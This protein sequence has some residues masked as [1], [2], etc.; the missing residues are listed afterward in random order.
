MNKF[1]VILLGVF[2]FFII[3]GVFAF[4][5]FRGGGSGSFEPVTIWGTLESQDIDQ[6]LL[7][8]RQDVDKEFEAAY[9]EIPEEEFDQTLLEALAA[10]R[11]PDLVFLPE[12]LIV[13]HEDKIFVVPFESLSLRDFRDRFIE[14]GELYVRDDGILGLPFSV[15][16][17]VLYWNRTLFSNVGI[18]STPAYWDQFF[19]LSQKLTRKDERGN[20]LQGA[21]ALGEYDNV[22]HAKEILALLMLQAGTPIVSRANEG[23]KVSLTDKFNF[24]EVPAEA[25]LR[26]Y[27]EFANPVKNV[28]SWNRSLP[29]SQDAFV[30]GDIAMY[31]GFASELFAIQDR[32]PNLNFDVASLPQARDSGRVVTFGNMQA[33]SVMRGATDVNSA[34]N[35]LRVLTSPEVLTLWEDISGLP[36]V[37]RSL[38]Q[39]DPADAYRVVFHNGALVS[40]A[41]LDPNPEASDSIFENMI[42]DVT[43]GRDRISS[44][45]LGAQTALRELLQ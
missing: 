2:V 27:T 43:S 3:A 28:Y 1:Q 37:R 19:E 10:G 4:A 32:N 15:D 42:E 12:D 38:L 13:R 14:E 40:D 23:F 6:L 41:F 44:A 18:A 35:A 9:R 21:I 20:I 25:A 24:P 39:E 31:V 7:L 16:P 30:V 8:V 36:P 5:T 26:F 33:I 17:M 45:V 22:R 29:D 11:G 34:F